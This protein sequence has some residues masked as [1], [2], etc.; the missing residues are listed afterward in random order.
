[1][2]SL[3][4][5]IRQ[6]RSEEAQACVSRIVRKSENNTFVRRMLALTMVQNIG[7]GANSYTYERV[8]ELLAKI[9]RDTAKEKLVLLSRSLVAL[10]SACS[11]S[12]NA[13]HAREYF[14]TDEHV[15]Y[16]RHDD[17]TGVHVRSGD[18]SIVGKVLNQ[19][20]A[21]LFRGDDRAIFWMKLYLES[22]DPCALRRRRRGD[23]LF[24][25]M[26]AIFPTSLQLV[27]LHRRWYEDDPSSSDGL[28]VFNAA[29]SCIHRE[30]IEKQADVGPCGG[31]GGGGGGDD[32]EVPLDDVFDAAEEEILRVDV[33]S[34]A[35]NPLYEAHWKARPP[36]GAPPKLRDTYEG[37]DE[38]VSFMSY[39][40]L[41]N[42]ER[43]IRA[44]SIAEAAG[45][46]EAVS[47]LIEDD[48]VIVARGSYDHRRRRHH[49]RLHRLPLPPP[50]GAASKLIDF[51]A[52]RGDRG[53]TDEDIFRGG[54]RHRQ[55]EEQ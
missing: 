19:T 13:T 38:G 20:E 41:A 35:H 32:D 10:M 16:E 46:G 25:M 18:C 55:H 22:I 23:V 31:G 48:V 6:G 14:S 51:Y 27:E 37:A 29:L 8:A 40:E 4:A 45:G 50:A 11:K 2:P 21:C 1:M 9:E 36:R 54:V 49:P 17:F 33:L 47:N 5:C 44:V 52:S 26:S 24:D 53:V 30:Q 15:T 7:V 3:R 39:R 42:E 12:L 43:T 34:T 28:Y